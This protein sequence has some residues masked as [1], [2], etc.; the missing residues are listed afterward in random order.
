MVAST[1]CSPVVCVLFVVDFEGGGGGGVA[2]Q[3]I[4]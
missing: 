1:V 4:E 2:K 3:N